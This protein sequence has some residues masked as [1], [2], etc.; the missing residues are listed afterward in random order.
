ME[1][2]EVKE[3][4]GAAAANLIQD[5][6]LVGL[7]SGT[8]SAFFVKS[9]AKRCQQGL[10]IKAVAS[11]EA[12][13]K[14]AKKLNISLISINDVTL[15]DV[16]V[17]GADEIDEKKQMIKGRGGALVREKILAS[18]SREMIVI[19]DETKLVSQLGKCPL[20]IEVIPYGYN[21][22]FHK[23]EK[24]GY[25]GKWRKNQDGSYYVTDNRN[26]IFDLHFDR[27]CQD[28]R[29]DHEILIHLP[30]I[31]DTGFFFDLAGRVVIGFFD[32][33]IVIR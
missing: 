4:I 12:T 26:Y 6:M 14:L 5:D 1:I 25:K 3:Q 31:V 8:T 11:S 2:D 22:T 24:L 17:D 23:L 32:G 18:M 21:G 13:E 9:L 20:P 30:G 7:G 29:R 19:V 16:T 15:L 27:F 28:P 33:Q 10:K